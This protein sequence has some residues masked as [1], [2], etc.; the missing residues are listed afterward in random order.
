MEV[1][2]E[3]GERITDINHVSI[4]NPQTRVE[5]TIYKDRALAAA[6]TQ[7]MGLATTNTTL[8]GGY[9]TWYGPSTYDLKVTSTSKG[10]A[11]YHGMKRSDGQVIL[12]RYLP[13]IYDTA[14][15]TI[16]V[17]NYDTKHLRAAPMEIVGAP[18]D[19]YVI[20]PL[21]AV[22]TMHYGGTNV[23]TESTDNLI[24]G[25]DDGAVAAGPAVEC[26]GFITA[27]ANTVTTWMMALDDINAASTVVNK[28]LAVKN[29]G[30]GEFAGNAGADN[31][32]TI[33]LM[34]AIVW[35][36]ITDEGDE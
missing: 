33:S 22:L 36:G 9:F 34:Y 4:L 8:S 12:P 6:I 24:F 35:T 29:S 30:D 28:N 11:I 26:T 15:V 7:P 23:F 16:D 18:G 13:R 3:Q 2:N 1:V 14:W 5:Q 27:D 21:S 20:M 10:S 31:T 17:N 32:L 19:G 25:W